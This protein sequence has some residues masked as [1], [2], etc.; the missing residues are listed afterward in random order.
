MN[1]QFNNPFNN[2]FNTTPFNNATQGTVPFNTTP[3]NNVAVSNT[4]YPTN[5]HTTQFPLIPPFGTQ[6]PTYQFPASQF[7]TYQPNQPNQPNT[8]QMQYVS[9]IQ[10][11]PPNQLNVQSIQQTPEQEQAD[12]KDLQDKFANINI[13]KGAFSEMFHFMYATQPNTVINFKPA[14]IQKTLYGSTKFNSKYEQDFFKQV[15]T[16]NK[17]PFGKYLISY[18]KDMV[19]SNYYDCSYQLIVTTKNKN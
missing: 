7:P 3:F 15:A 18:K 14:G 10:P 2:P 12:M 6:Y 5:Q 19:Q 8:Q 17:M 9:S 11:N 13:D 1:G 4:Q 16:Y